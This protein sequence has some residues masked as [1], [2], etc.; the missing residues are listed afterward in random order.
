MTSFLLAGPSGEP[1]TL[2]EAK[3][4]LRVDG[5]DEDSLVTTLIAAARIHIESVTNRALLTQ[6]WR[7][8]LDAWPASRIVH[9]PVGPL[10]SVDAIT[11]HDLEG[12]PVPVPLAQF[13]PETGAMPARLFLPAAV[14]GMPVL[15]TSAAIEIDY[16]AGYGGDS[17]DVPADLR[18]ALLGLVAYWFEHRDAVVMA[19]SGAV[20]PPGFDRLV[21]AY[22][23]VSL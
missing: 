5:S 19:G 17:A 15:R 8:T 16:T 2:A 1:V 7:L 21:S 23:R 20:V 9:L 18:Q 22:R 11:A 12:T 3:A 10:V 13:Q 14:A 4:F 6:Q